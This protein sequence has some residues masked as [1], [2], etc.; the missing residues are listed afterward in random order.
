MTR[1]PSVCLRNLINKKGEK[2][3]LSAEIP[4]EEPSRTNAS[5]GVGFFFFFLFWRGRRGRVGLSHLITTVR[6]EEERWASGSS[7]TGCESASN[8]LTLRTTCVET[9]LRGGQ[10]RLSRG[11]RLSSDSAGQVW[12]LRTVQ[13]PVSRPDATCAQLTPPN[14]RI[15]TPPARRCVSLYN[16]FL[17]FYFILFFLAGIGPR[18]ARGGGLRWRTMRRFDS[19][20]TWHIGSSRP[21]TNSA[22]DSPSYSL[23]PCPA[24]IC[25]IAFSSVAAQS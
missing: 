11:K 9:C 5:A 23:C 6:E 20:E 14:S 12:F 10:T 17:Q 24:P 21:P 13:Q 15:Y 2:G 16:I 7:G 8:P 22:P 25:A 18:S 4:P 19:M 3:E 1:C